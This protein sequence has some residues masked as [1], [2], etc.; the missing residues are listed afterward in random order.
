[1]S[2]THRYISAFVL[3]VLYG[4]I[5]LST[6]APLALR[7]AV[8]A[9]ALTGECAG[10]CGLCGC[11][12][13]RSASRTC[14]CWQKKLRQE[15]SVRDDDQEQSDCCAENRDSGKIKTAAISSLPCGSGKTMA[16]LGAEQTDILPFRFSQS[17]PA[18]AE[19]PINVQTRHSWAD[20]PGE[21]PDQ[22]PKVVSWS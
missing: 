16:L 2:K 17:P 11:S 5:V 4:L 12:P 14:C 20:W 7:S 6:L 9:H 10:E 8:I 13:E 1:M 15:H 19:S 3:C 21:P 18:A 22:P